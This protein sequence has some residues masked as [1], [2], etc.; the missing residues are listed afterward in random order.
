M[1]RF[2]RSELAANGI[3]EIHQPGLNRLDLIRPVVTKDVVDFRHGLAQIC[4]LCP[5]GPLE[6]FPGMGIVK[7]DSFL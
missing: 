2:S 5:I 7:R 1:E 3:E 4:S 6:T